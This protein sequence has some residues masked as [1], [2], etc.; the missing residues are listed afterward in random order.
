MTSYPIITFQHIYDPYVNGVRLE[1][2]ATQQGRLFQHICDPR[3]STH[4]FQQPFSYLQDRND[5]T[6]DEN[7][8]TLI[9][10]DDISLQGHFQQNQYYCNILKVSKIKSAPPI[11]PTFRLK[12]TNL[13]CWIIIMGKRIPALK[14]PFSIRRQPPF[15]STFRSKFKK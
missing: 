5:V 4:I 8:W 12:F 6:Q 1:N 15:F 3:L 2:H 9:I 10:T 13:S 14:K 7:V 11:L